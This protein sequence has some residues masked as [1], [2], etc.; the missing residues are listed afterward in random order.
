MSYW[1]AQKVNIVYKCGGQYSSSS[2]VSAIL[3]HSPALFRYH[4]ESD[5]NESLPIAEYDDFNREPAN[6]PPRA[7]GGQGHGP[8]FDNHLHHDDGED[9]GNPFDPPPPPPPSRRPNPNDNEHFDENSESF[10]D[11]HY[12]NEDNNRIHYRNN[13]RPQNREH[14]HQSPIRNGDEFLNYLTETDGPS[15]STSRNSDNNNNDNGNGAG[16]FYDDFYDFWIHRSAN[17][18]IEL[19]DQTTTSDHWCVYLF[20][21]YGTLHYTRNSD[22]FVF[23]VLKAETIRR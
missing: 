2:D 5:R 18:L 13:Q 8:G 9:T 22:Y 12:G 20:G 4:E 7:R 17:K 11:D 10:A 3:E 1:D 19:I 15:R 6:P 21:N 23:L 14:F 16:P